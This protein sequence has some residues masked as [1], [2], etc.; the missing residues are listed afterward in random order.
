LDLADAISYNKM[1][2]GHLS[3]GQ[4]AA[5]R[6]LLDELTDKGIANT[7]SYHGLLNAR[8][9]AGDLRGAWKIISEMQINGISPNA[10]TCAILL[11]A[12]LQSVEEVSRVLALVDAMAEPMDEVL[13]MAVA[14]ACFVLIGWI[15]FR[16]TWKSSSNK[17]LQELCPMRLTDSMAP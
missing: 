1:M 13:F 10:V 9:N 3:Q 4:E 14:E 17:E 2:K 12:R 11:K 6:Q 16:S 5:A 7:T 8:V 15:S